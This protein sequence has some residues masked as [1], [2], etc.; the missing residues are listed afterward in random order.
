MNTQTHR[1]VFNKSRGCLMAVG[2]HSRSPGGGCSGAR[3]GKRY[4]TTS[5]TSALGT[6]PT[7]EEAIKL[8]VGTVTDVR[9]AIMTAPKIDIVRSEGADISKSGELIL[10][11]SS[12]STQT[13]ARPSKTW[14]AAR[15]SKA[16]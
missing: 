16:C 5:R 1:L 9:G 11:A 15:T 7:S 8:G 2:E 6:T 4:A 14:V 3:R 12:N 13:L 10:G